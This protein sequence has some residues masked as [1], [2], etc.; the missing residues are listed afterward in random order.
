MKHCKSWDY[1]GTIYQ[2]VQDFVTIHSR[3]PLNAMVDQCWSMLIIMFP[4]RMAMWKYLSHFQTNPCIETMVTNPCAMTFA[5]L[6]L[7]YKLHFCRPD[8]AAC[9][10]TWIVNQT[11][12]AHF[13]N[14]RSQGS[15]SGARFPIAKWGLLPPRSL[16]PPVMFY[17]CFCVWLHLAKNHFFIFIS[18]SSQTQQLEIPYKWRF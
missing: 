3:A 13:T 10:K 7:R 14:P 4:I 6:L 8:E 12:L 15:L 1:N 17:P 11:A 5:V 2:L 16:R 18:S 9:I